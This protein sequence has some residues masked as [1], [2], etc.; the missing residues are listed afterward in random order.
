MKN[1]LLKTLTCFASISAI[2]SAA[3]IISTSCNSQDQQDDYWP[4][5]ALPR[6]VY[7]I[8]SK[9]HTLYGF[10]RN[11]ERHYD[12]YKQ[13]DTIWIPSD[14]K[15][16][17]NYAFFDTDAS[18]SKIPTYLKKIAFAEGSNCSSIGQNAFYGCSSLTSVDFSNCKTLST[19]GNYAFRNCNLISSINF[20][21]CLEL[22]SIGS[23]VFAV[24]SS[25]T[26][27]VFPD[28]LSEIGIEAF[29][30]CSSLESITLNKELRN[31]NSCAFR[32]C[33]S[34]TNIE[35]NFTSNFNMVSIGSSAFADIATNNGKI[36]C[37]APET[38]T[39]ID[40]LNWLQGKAPYTIRQGSFPTTG[41]EAIN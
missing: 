25:L 35:W 34:L 4:E 39:S 10:T 17:S 9:D 13:F 22:T 32:D 38:H 12:D 8:D 29:D 2:G 21:N 24:C 31:I 27:I 18:A 11:F 3:T 41:W 30:S 15:Y 6:E 14:V 19:I 36:K 20:S 33:S 28:N 7:D 26:S 5:D 37:T 16:I 40:L 23:N 1:K